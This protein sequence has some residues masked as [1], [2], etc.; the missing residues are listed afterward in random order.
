MFFLHAG[1]WLDRLVLWAETK[2]EECPTNA[3]VWEDRSRGKKWWLH[4]YAAES[5]ELLKSAKHGALGRFLVGSEVE[6]LCA[7]LPTRQNLP[8]PSQARVLGTF[9]REGVVELRPW[10][11]DVLVLDGLKGWSFLQ[12]LQAGGELGG[13]IWPSAEISQIGRVVGVVGRLLA[14]QRFVPTLSLEEEERAVWSPLLYRGDKAFGELKR[15]LPAVFFALSE[16]EEDAAPEVDRYACL[17]RW[18]GRYV[19]WC[20]H[21]LAEKIVDLPK[22]PNEEVEI[23][24]RVRT[25]GRGRGPATRKQ[26]TQRA[27]QSGE[28]VEILP[29]VRTGGRGRG[30]ATRKQ[31]TQRAVQSGD[32]RVH[33]RWLR[34]LCRSAYQIKGTVNELGSLKSQAETWVRPLRIAA[35]SSYRLVFQ[36]VSPDEAD[37][38]RE[39]AE[40]R[41][42]WEEA[43]RSG[44]R[45][46]ETSG[47]WSFSSASLEEEIEEAED[48]TLR[49]LA[50]HQEE[51][52]TLLPLSR[53]VQEDAGA[54]EYALSALGRATRLD[55]Q[56][57]KLLERAEEIDRL[58][59]STEEA[60]HFL[61]VVA[62]MLQ[63]SDVEVLLPSWWRTGIQERLRTKIR[64]ETPKETGGVFSLEQL[65][66][67]RWE[68]A[69]GD[70][71]LSVEEL[72]RLA[73][74]KRELVK[75][76]GR[77]VLL[78]PEELKEA[79]KLLR[80]RKEQAS[81]RDLLFAS[82][83]M[84]SPEMP[85]PV[86]EV[87]SEGW[88]EEIFSQ[89][90]K[91][92]SGFGPM[93][94]PQGFVGSLR[95]YQR[96]GLAWLCWM[97]R[98]GLG[99]CL[100]DDMGLG[101]TIQTLAMLQHHLSQTTKASEKKPSLLICPM[102]VLDNW[103][104]EAIR[105]TPKLRTMLHHGAS[106]QTG[107][108]LQRALK[109]TDLVIST[110]GTL[111]RDIESLSKIAWR[112]VILDEAQAIKNHQTKTSR[113]AAS[114][115]AQ[116]RISL[117]G[118]PVENHV[119]D[120]WSQM[121]FLNPGLLKDRAWFSRHFYVPI[122]LERDPKASQ[123]LKR[124]S[125]PFVLRR[126]KTDKDIIDDLPDKIESKVYCHLTKEQVGLYEAALEQMTVRIETT[127]DPM[128]RRGLILSLLTQLK[129]I[130]N[131]P[132]HFLKEGIAQ[133]ERSG[134]LLQLD[135]L[136]AQIIGRGE[137]VLLFTQYTEM[138]RLLVRYLEERFHRDVLYLHGEIS[139]AKRT[140]MVSAFQ[141]AAGPPF[142][143][144]SLK[145]GGTGLNL[146]RASHVVHFDRWWNPAVENQATDR[147]FRIGQTQKVQVHKFVCVGTFEEKLDESIERKVSI[148]KDV[149]ADGETWLTELSDNALREVFRLRGTLGEE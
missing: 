133:A 6:M 148:A 8:L 112:V 91:G 138:G 39:P 16:M 145:A 13:D 3:R 120:L 95:P 135:M 18:V 56:F 20:V 104:R 26:S 5:K 100:A 108:E 98:W 12:H 53:L 105:F 137:A 64:V 130:C 149:I 125:G 80:S 62:E 99:A 63:R 59:L 119:F 114:L 87:V 123:R 36:L 113:A 106:R 33:E 43:E 37:L 45:G 7:W 55:P 57:T 25:G 61:T 128:Q 28:E 102:S 77:W 10:C 68:V 29:R 96:R 32:E 76:R 38:W 131:H 65:M 22:E 136:A 21:T 74:L 132:A 84:E 140:E 47:G 73:A 118:T 126:L 27:V 44:E 141:A 121:Q 124:I 42:G 94:E 34:G 9:P 70:Q 142:F 51:H 85:L 31:S 24:P 115:E 78:D 139:R 129:Q 40:Q 79:A 1:L 69:L 60:A 48:W 107:S 46:V 103:Q 54:Y 52:S 72:K 17:G 67:F 89:F 111:L 90:Q 83:G 146:T 23:L 14:Q 88:I 144:L 134:K 110:Y 122:Q 11:V 109:K 15:S 82:L 41:E 50:R 19:D 86:G 97:G 127:E 58:K 2:T 117:T 116:Q 71:S 101:K 66:R 30:P 93:E 81:I 92:A 75:I 35:S 147:A 143:V 4:P 49:L